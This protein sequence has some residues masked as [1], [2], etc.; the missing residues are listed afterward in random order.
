MTAPPLLVLLP[1]MDGTGDLFGPFLQA[2]GGVPAVQVI[3]FSTH[4]PADYAALIETIKAQL[5]TDRPYVVLAE[6]FSGPLGIEIAAQQP[7]WLRGLVLC[8][9]FARNPSIGL[10]LASPV[11]DWL[12]I[13][14]LPIAPMGLMLLG[15]ARP[16][17]LRDALERALRRVSPAVLRARL[18]AVANVDVSHLLKHVHVPCLYLRAS[19]DR[20][21]SAAAASLI[22]QRVPNLRVIEFRAPHALLQTAPEASAAQVQDFVRSLPAD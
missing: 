18:R 6:S 22:A 14:A 13:G 17:P 4:Q 11:L 9:T 20:L 16:S 7:A 21:V 15:Q 19:Q 8:C 12:P 1:G 3:R 5:P 10:W 2:L